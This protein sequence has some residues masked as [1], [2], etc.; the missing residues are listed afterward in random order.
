MGEIMDGRALAVSTVWMKLQDWFN[1]LAQAR[2][3]STLGQKCG[4]DREDNIA[5]DLRATS[6]PAR[7]PATPRIGS[8]MSK[9]SMRFA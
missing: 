8:D 5:V 7:T 4:M 6:T 2:P 1:S 9:P 3:A